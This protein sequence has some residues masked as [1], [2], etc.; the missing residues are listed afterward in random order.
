MRR[1]RA[2][3]QGGVIAAAAVWTLAAWLLGTPVTSTE[4]P[5]RAAHTE[6][7]GVIHVHT[8]ESD[9]YQDVPGTIT[10]AQEAEL[11]FVVITDH[12]TLGAKRFEGYAD[13]LLLMVGTEI[14]TDT[15]H[16]LGLGFDEPTYRFPHS[17]LDV[18]RDISDLGGTALVAHPT[19]PRAELRWGDA[20]A[21]GGWG[22]E[23]LNADTQWRSASRLSV[24]LS[25]LA[26]PF[27]QDYALS[28]LLTRPSALSWWDELLRRRHTAGVAAADTH[29]RVPSYASMFRVARNH[30]LL[31]RP[32]TGDTESDMASIITALSLGR[33]FVGID[34]IAPTRG[35]FFVAERDSR[36]WT[37][38]ETVSPSPALTLRAGGIQED[39]AAFTLLKDG[40][41][42]THALGALEATAADTGVYRV[43]VSLPGWD[44]PWITTNPIYLFDRSAIHR[45][46]ANSAL[47]PRPGPVAPTV[48]LDGFDEGAVFFPASD[49]ASSVTLET[50]EVV[51]G[52]QTARV[53]YR[54]GARSADNPSPYVAVANVEHRDLSSHEGLV[55]TLK[56]D[57]VY[58]LWLQL[59]DRN[60][61]SSEQTEWWSASL[62]ATE[63]WQQ[64]AVPFG[65]LSSKDP[66]TDGQLDLDEIEGIFLIIDVDSVPEN[67]AGTLWLD[68]VALY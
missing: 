32:L 38:G 5:D 24:L 52:R 51:D 44:I 50:D 64:L 59:R 61:R 12:N 27:S 42:V 2:G 17:V 19:S 25:I 65:L 7:V 37:M 20:S 18:L 35:F 14:S 55:V 30:V 1:R 41:V 11:D 8:D 67:T 9:G 3:L 47:P 54:L 29:T 57:G 36:T 26:Y 48:Y 49:S 58:R 21:P 33:L 68:E 16:I 6:V 40:E 28:R 23:V 43:E 45:R 13:R 4:T 34:G 53:A 39:E 56:A 15:G 31:D 46:D 60:P 63:R 10:A 66:D 22:I 62:K